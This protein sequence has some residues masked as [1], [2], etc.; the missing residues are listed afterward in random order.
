M[1]EQPSSWPL[2]ATPEGTY[3]LGSQ[4]G[5]SQSV[6]RG[7]TRAH[8]ELPAYELT[9]NMRRQLLQILIGG[10]SPRRLLAHASRMRC[11]ATASKSRCLPLPQSLIHALKLHPTSDVACALREAVRHQMPI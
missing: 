1:Q 8:V 11:P 9:D 4:D 6:P 7:R 3:Q 5:S 2:L 10:R